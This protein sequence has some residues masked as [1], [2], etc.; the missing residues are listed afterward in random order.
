MNNLIRSS[1]YT[2]VGSLVLARKKVE[3]LVEELIQNN[4]LTQE[5]GKRV[6]LDFIHNMEDRRN[7]LEQQVNGVV[8][9]LLL[10]FKLPGR[11]ELEAQVSDWI[12]KLKSGTLPDFSG[13]D[14]SDKPFVPQ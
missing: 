4:H 11:L 5:E 3:E 14:D 2:G 6:V 13:K 8:D 9:E 7:S 10:L 12:S 1:V